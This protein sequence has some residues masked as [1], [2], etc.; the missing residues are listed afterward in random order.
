M[1]DKCGSEMFQRGSCVQAFYPPGGTPRLYG[2]QDARCYRK[3]AECA[4]VNMNCHNLPFRMNTDLGEQW[5]DPNLGWIGVLTGLFQAPFQLT[6]IF[7]SWKAMLTGGCYTMT[8]RWGNPWPASANRLTQFFHVFC[9]L[10]HALLIACCCLPALSTLGS[11]SLRG[12]LFAHD[13]STIIKCKDKYYVFFTGP[14]IWSKSS[15]DKIFWTA[16]PNVFATTPAWVTNAVPG[17]NRAFGAP[18]VIFLN[19]QYY[20]YYVVTIIGTQVSAIGL[21][22]NPSLD[23]TDPAYQWTDR[24]PVIQTS[25]T[26]PYNALDPSL[27]FDGAGNLWMSF[28]SYWNGIYLV[29]LDPATGLRISTHSPTYHVAYNSSIEASC[30]FW[31]GGYYYLFV[32]WGS[33]CSEGVNSTYN[34]RVGRSTSITGPYL[35]RN[36]V[37]MV[38]GGGTLFL[39][40]TGKFAGPGQIGIL[41]EGGAQWFSYHYYDADAW[42]PKLNVYGMPTLDLEPLSW[43]ADNWPVFTNDWSAVYH[44]QN[45]AR[46]DNGQYHGL[47]VGGASIQSDPALGRVLNLNG[48]NQYVWL[49]PGVAN[50]RTFSA[51]VKW[52]GGGAWQRIFDFG[53]DTSST[54]M[55]TPMDG[56]GKLNCYVGTN[57]SYQVLAGPKALPVGVWTH[58]AVTLDGQNGILYVNGAP[59]AT[60]MIPFSPLAVHAVTNHLGRSKFVA[61]PYFN[62]QI[63]MF[64]AYGRVLSAA[65]ITAPLLVIAK[66]ADGSA[67]WPGAS[68]LFNGSATDYADRPLGASNLSWQVHYI[69]DNVTNLVLG[70]LKGV[71]CGVFTVPT[72]AT[73]GGVYQISLTATD[74]VNRQSTVTATLSPANAPAATNAYLPFSSYHPFSVDAG[75][76]NGHYP[77]MLNNSVN[78]LPSDVAPTSG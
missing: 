7:D 45:D 76:A 12:N 19:G 40:G 13:P 34:I 32:N 29:Q 31:R 17:S 43:T 69:I 78:L 61:D 22:T 16:G 65:E 41:S 4:N 24:G 42:N 35:D 63:A 5:T 18:D 47:L 66:P 26:D 36:G 14:G 56:N 46:D 9:R 64:R 15:T 38:N 74:S 1:E 28:G 53:T 75:D 59:M 62:G 67:Y 73:G 77:G 72:N 44:F 11:P 37:D 6:A 30:V 58:V 3:T 21:A 23:P 39:E 25:P 55:L 71:T 8:N 10:R 54:V 20:L 68:I 52:T 51:V 50:A 57:Y 48:T 60:N 70:P 2:R 49:P 33:C 27:T